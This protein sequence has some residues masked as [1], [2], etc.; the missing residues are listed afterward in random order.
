MLVDSD[1]ALDAA[2]AAVIVNLTQVKAVGWL[3]E[4]VSSITDGVSN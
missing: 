1:A 2:A 4:L 3:V